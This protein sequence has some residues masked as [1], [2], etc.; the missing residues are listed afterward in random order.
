MHTVALAAR[1]I[2]DLLLLVAA[3][4]VEGATIRT[5]VHVELTEL[6]DFRTAGD[7][8]PDGLVRVERVPALVDIAE[9]HGV[10]DADGTR[11]R[12]LLAGDHLEQRRLARAV[13]PDDA[14]DAARR[15]LDRQVVDQRAAF[16]ALLDALELDDHIAEALGDRNDDLRIA[17]TDVLGGIDQLLVRLDTG[18]GLGLASLR[19]GG[20]PLL[21]AR[22]RLL[23]ARFVTRFLLHALGLCLQVCGVIALV[24]NATAAVEFENPARNVVEEVAVVGDHHH[25]AGIVAQML[26]QPRNGLSVEVVGRFI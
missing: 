11:I 4:E 3:L 15:Q 8:L 25:G 14:D 16:E 13:R 6:D 5:A 24:G 9:M 19:A 17:G 1:E 20:D 12:L 23:A 7:F 2:A 21:F 10:A 18:L 22:Q 26:F